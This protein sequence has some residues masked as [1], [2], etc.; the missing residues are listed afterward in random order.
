MSD[1]GSARTPPRCAKAARLI[2]SAKAEAEQIKAQE[3]D[4]ATSKQKSL[5]EFVARA[6][7][8]TTR[9]VEAAQAK[10]AEA[11]R[12]LAM[13]DEAHKAATAKLADADAKLAA[14]TNAHEAV[15][16]AQAALSKAL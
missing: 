6:T 5:N 12:K 9:A 3:L 1:W 4:R 11:D 15:K 2:E 16:L 10:E 8:E 7:Q 13:A 14:A